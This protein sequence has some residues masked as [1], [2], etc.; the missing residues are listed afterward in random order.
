M[1]ISNLYTHDVIVQRLSSV[2]DAYGG[3]KKTWVSHLASFKCRIYSPKKEMVVEN[4]GRVEKAL[5][6][7]IGEE[8]DVISGDKVIDGTDEYL[9]KRKYAT[10]AISTIHHLELLLEKIK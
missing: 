5:Y 7:C 6:H 1:G 2:T 9:V 3:E 10:Y 4:I 8:V